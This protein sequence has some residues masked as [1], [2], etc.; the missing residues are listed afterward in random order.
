MDMTFLFLIFS[1]EGERQRAIDGIAHFRDIGR[2]FETHN[3]LSH[4][5][6][7]L[8]YP[9][10]PVKWFHYYT[11]LETIVRSHDRDTDIFICGTVMTPFP[12]VFYEQ[13]RMEVYRMFYKNTPYSVF[14]FL[15]LIR[16]RLLF[17]STT[18]IEN[19]IEFERFR[20]STTRTDP[21]Y[22]DLRSES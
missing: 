10:S 3:S 18:T 11:L 6:E 1:V 19:Q 4:S 7:L 9:I 13:T 21:I 8:P 14:R 12:V 5:W 15:G 22:H 20:I 16:F 2:P 17:V